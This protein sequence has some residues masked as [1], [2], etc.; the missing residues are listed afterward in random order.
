MTWV[1][2]SW[3]LNKCLTFKNRVERERVKRE[4]TIE[5]DL[6][7]EAGFDKTC[8]ILGLDLAAEAGVEEG[9]FFMGVA[10]EIPQSR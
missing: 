7:A 3:V 8:T 2:L 4:V 10:G 1:V 9:G 6:A 5:L